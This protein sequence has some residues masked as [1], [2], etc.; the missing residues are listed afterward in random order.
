MKI[1]L[2]LKLISINFNLGKP[3]YFYRVEDTNDSQ[4]SLL[5]KSHDTR[6]E[7]NRTRE[8]FAEKLKSLQIL[9]QEIEEDTVA[10]LSNR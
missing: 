3:K 5:Q 7:L 8:F 6:E 1:Y 4:Q 2:I 9:L 10:N